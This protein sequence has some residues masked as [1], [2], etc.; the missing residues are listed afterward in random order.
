MQ[1]K[2]QFFFLLSLSLPLMFTQVSAQEQN[3]FDKV[4]SAIQALENLQ[5]NGDNLK[6]IDV[7][8]SPPSRNVE[9]SAVKNIAK[10]FE[11][12][13]NKRLNTVDPETVNP[14][15]AAPPKEDSA[16]LSEVPPN[17]RFYFKE[18]LFIPAYKQG[19]LFVNSEPTYGVESNADVMELLLERPASEGACAIVSSKSNVMMK[20][21]PSNSATYLDISSIE[22]FTGPGKSGDDEYVVR[23]SYFEKPA[24]AV[25]GAS[26]NVSVLCRIPSD[27][28]SNLKSYTL[29][30]MNK[31]MGGVFSF[32]MPSYIEI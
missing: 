18:N 32:K 5:V 12:P 3:P 22:F 16:K 17:T 1:R 30:H 26:V 2:P 4:D 9:D 28:K 13:N 6:V 10:P 23:V 24:K 27:L 8:K 7:Q 29:G 14:A 25:E 20:G 21:S 15:I 31:Q 19:V 11:L